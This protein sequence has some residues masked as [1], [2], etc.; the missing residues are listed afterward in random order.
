MNDVETLRNA[1]AIQDMATSNAACPIA[2]VPEHSGRI[3]L[4]YIGLDGKAMRLDLTAAIE[5]IA[6]RKVMEHMRAWHSHQL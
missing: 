6:E 3:I 5:E 1:S 4:R 2:L